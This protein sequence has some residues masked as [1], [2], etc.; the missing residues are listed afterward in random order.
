MGRIAEATLTDGR[1]IQY[2]VTDNPPC[3]GMKYTYFTPD[4]SRVVQF[5]LR[6]GDARDPDVHR[7]L[8][9]IIG[10]YNPTVSE[11]EGGAQGNSAATAAYFARK[12]CWRLLSA[13]RSSASSARPIPPTSSF[14]PGPPIPWSCGGLTSGAAGSP[15]ATAGFCSPGSWGIS[16]RWWR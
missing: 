5:F 8:E 14:S 4:R 1:K 16:A 11:E 3:G 13:P 6:P 10:A 2:V 12:F 15:P 7:R 9:A